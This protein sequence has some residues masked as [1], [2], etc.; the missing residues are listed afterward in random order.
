MHGRWSGRRGGAHTTTKRFITH[1]WITHAHTGECSRLELRLEETQHTRRTRTPRKGP[2]DAWDT[3]AGNARLLD[4]PRC[5]LALIEQKKELRPDLGHWRALAA[6][7]QVLSLASH[8]GSTYPRS[9]TSTSSS[10]TARGGS[11][12]IAQLNNA[13]AFNAFVNQTSTASSFSVASP[14]APSAT[15]RSLGRNLVRTAP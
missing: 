4:Q 9:S 5:F 13:P 6:Y 14:Q 3:H 7:L 10:S 8:S 15:T 11:A 1:A 2:A 12:P